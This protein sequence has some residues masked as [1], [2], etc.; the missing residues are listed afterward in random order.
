MYNMKELLRY[1]WQFKTHDRAKDFLYEWCHDALTSG[2]RPF[3]RLGLTLN[4][5]KDQILN[6]FKHRIT[7]AV[8]EGTN[9]KIKTLKRQ[10]YGY[11]DMEYGSSG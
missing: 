3:I 8:V 7:N 5:Y 6:F 11:R 4:K 10:A 9:N 2:I 1:F